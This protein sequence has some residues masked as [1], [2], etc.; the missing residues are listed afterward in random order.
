MLTIPLFAAQANVLWYIFPLA[1]VISLVYSASRFELPELILRRSG[2][3]F[4]QILI[5]MGIVLAV[6][7]LLSAWL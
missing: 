4:L 1:A 3:L 6:L 5:F 7:L 2:R